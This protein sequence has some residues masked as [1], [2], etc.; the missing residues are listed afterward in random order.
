[1]CRYQ[2]KTRSRANIFVFLHISQYVIVVLGGVFIPPYQNHC[3]FKDLCQVRCPLCI[4]IDEFQLQVGKIEL[5]IEKACPQVAVSHI[6]AKRRMHFQDAHDTNL[7]PI[8]EC[9]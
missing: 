9:I 6:L 3:L 2:D 4:K 1:M 5:L 7:Q 8:T